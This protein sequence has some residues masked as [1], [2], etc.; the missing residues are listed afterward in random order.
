MI[1]GQD[2]PRIV[3]VDD[4]VPL[5]TA[6]CH[7]LQDAGFNPTGFSSPTAAM[8]AIR[9]GEFELLLT[10]LNMPEMDGISLVQAVLQIDPNLACVIMTGQGSIGTAVDAMKTGA[11]D[12]ILKP[13]KARAAL[14]VLT[15]ARELRNLRLENARLHEALREHIKELEIRNEELSLFGAAVSHDLRAP[16]NRIDG[17]VYILEETSGHLLDADARESLSFVKTSVTEMKKLIAGLLELAMVREVELVVKPF[18]LS[19]RAHLMFQAL[20]AS[21]GDKVIKIDIQPGLVATADEEMMSIVLT[22]LLSN[23]IK[24]SSKAERPLITVGQDHT[25]PRAPFFIRDNGVGFDPNR[26][27]KLFIPFKRLHS[28][29]EFTGT[30]IGLSTVHRIIRR[31]GGT[32]WATSELGEG[33]TFYF[34]LG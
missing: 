1:I 27:D 7:T 33:A 18:D 14:P 29:R 17:F 31:H 4:E 13:F 6:L 11:L 28:A 8:N 32:I 21:F 25:D 26:A 34:T 23:S 16:L 20:K 30:G 24:Y 2:A 22:N 3:I 12:Y 19:A 9:A 5:M 15:R 10:D